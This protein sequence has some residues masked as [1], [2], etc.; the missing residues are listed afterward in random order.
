MGASVATERKYRRSTG[1]YSA[2]EGKY[3]QIRERPGSSRA[4]CERAIEKR[5]VEA[6]T[7]RPLIVPCKSRGPSVSL[8]LKSREGLS[9]HAE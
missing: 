9:S 7:A 2:R 4:Q 3:E 1:G 6:L 5:N 8:G